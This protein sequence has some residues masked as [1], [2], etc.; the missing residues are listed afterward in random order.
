MFGT[1]RLRAGDGWRVTAIAGVATTLALLIT[2]CGCGGNSRADD[3]IGG[4]GGSHHWEAVADV[5]DSAT[6]LAE[7][8]GLAVAAAHDGLYASTD[9]GETW[10]ALEAPGLPPG[11]VL[12]LVGIPGPP[13]T[14]LAHVWGKGLH[15]SQDDGASWTPVA[16]PPESPLLASFLNPRATVVPWG[17]AAGDPE[18]G[19][20]A[21]PGGL[22]RSDDAGDSWEAIETSSPGTLNLLYTAVA[23]D[24]PRMV[25]ASQLPTGL[26]P[27]EYIDMVEGGVFLSEDGGLGWDDVTGDLPATALTGAAITADGGLVISALD[28]GVFEEID[29]TWSSLGGPSD[30]VAVSLSSDGINVASATRGIWREEDGAWTRAGEGPIVALTDRLALAHDGTVFQLVEG[31]GEAIPPESGGTVHVALSFHVNLYHSYRGDTN[32]DDGYGQ[33]IRVIR[34]TLDWLD[35]YPEVHGDWDIENAFSLDGVLP[36]DAPDIIDRIG[37]RVEAGTDGL[38]LMSWNNG[39]LAAETPEEF[40]ASITWAQDSYLDTFGQYDPGVQPQECMFSPQHIAG[41]RDLGVEWIT[42]FNSQTPFTALPGDLSLEGTALYNPVTLRHGPDD[43]MLLVP[44]YHHGDVLDHGG[45]AAWVTQIH[46]QHP[47]DTLLLVHMDADAVIWENFDLELSSLAGL[48][49]VE[50][51]T[52]QDYLDA[53]DPVADVELPGD[54]ADGTGDGFQSWAEKTFNHEIAT[55]I[56]RARETVAR[57]R[58]LGGGDEDVEAAVADALEPRLRALSTTH[59]GLAAPHLCDERMATARARVAEATAA[60]DAALALAEA[61]R[62][63]GAGE[64]ELVHPGDGGLGLLEIPIDVSAA[65]YEGP[66]ALAL[67]DPDGVELAAVVDVLDDTGD[68]VELRATLVFQV[69]AGGDLLSWRYDPDQPA[70]VT[71]GVSE[72]DLGQVPGLV[73]PFTE[74]AGERAEGQSEGPV[75]PEIDARNVRVRRSLT[76]DLSL[77]GGPGQVTRTTEVYD[78]FPGYVVRVDAEMGVADDPDWAESVALTPL[79]CEGDADTLTWRTHAGGSSLVRPVRRSQETWNGQAADGW[80]ALTC[81]DGDTLA[82]AHRVLE[83]TSLAFAPLRNDEGQ[84]LIAP[85]GTLWGDTPWHDARRI[86]GIGLGDLVTA[87]AGDQMYPAAPDWSGA[88]VSY[89]LW[90]HDELDEGVADLFAHPPLVRVG[91]D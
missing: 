20:L 56:A 2:G 60:A 33:D 61:L 50:Y 43:E 71:G 88:Q 5:G 19:Y 46:E 44:A 54:L 23:V 57:A 8:S 66:G 37:A 27:D 30:A 63:L 78:G 79:A 58:E 38:R 83:R 77:C 18:V 48:D 26:I 85:L 4:A 70:A 11:P 10:E 15:R 90:V 75:S 9:D 86:G 69:P 64:I 80:I 1:D 40:E 65:V 35:E 28:G 87:L 3:D 45:M 13:R 34:R 55:G 6:A 14:I 91:Q 53:H 39:A 41:Y 59:F 74:C 25:A 21:A 52:I 73:T 49:F 42:L 7:A 47:G 29:G 31:P 81:D 24:G 51:T 12:L 16:Q 82:V 62:P 17:A 72:A 32:D 36:Q 22:F 76:Y 67:F 89:T 84:A 68:P